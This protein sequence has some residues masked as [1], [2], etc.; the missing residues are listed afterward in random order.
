MVKRIL[1]ALFVL[2]LAVSFSTITFAQDQTKQQAK[3]DEKMEMKKEEKAMGPLKSVDCSPTCGFL[4]RS[5]DEKELTSVI[6]N[7]AKKMHK[8]DMTDKQIRDMMKTETTSEMQ[9]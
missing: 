8:M 1:A 2:M 9:K 6:K 3:K 4:C 5:H 7:H